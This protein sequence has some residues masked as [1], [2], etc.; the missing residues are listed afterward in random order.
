MG[1]VYANLTLKNAFDVMAVRQG[2]MEENEIRQI[3]VQALVDTGAGSLIISEG[4]QQALGLELKGIRPVAMADHSFKTCSISDPVEIHWE[5]RSTIIPAMVLEGA[6]EVLLGA[7]PLQEMDLI[8]D[9]ARHQ[10]IGAHGDQVV[11]RV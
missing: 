5:N 3:N 9:P 8:V 11:C 2:Y 1:Y 4:I 7:I 10:L 6:T